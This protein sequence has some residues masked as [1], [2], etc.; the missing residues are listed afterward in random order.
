MFKIL[1]YPFGIIINFFE[2][3][4]KYLHLMSK[5]FRSYRSWNLYLG[6]TVDHMI[7]IGAQSIPIV[8]LTSVFS[9]MVTS[10]QAAYQFESGFVPNWFV[11]SVVGE[12]IFLELGPML[13]GLVMTGRVGATISAEIGSMRVTEQIDALESLS[14]DPVSFLI[15]PRILAATIMFPVLVIIADIFGIT[16]GLVAAINAMDVSV[17]EFMKGL[18]QWFRPWDAWFGLIKGMFFGIAITS[19]AC[20]QGFYTT[21]GAQ[22]VGKSTTMT[23]VASCIAIVFLDFILAALLL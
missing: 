7:T 21:G 4:G 5:M 10:I 6:F 13:T 8:I 15:M 3:I 23:V 16:G 17:F 22:G 12:S 9:G 20:Y 11:G 1:F 14:F 19:I 18:K 2:S